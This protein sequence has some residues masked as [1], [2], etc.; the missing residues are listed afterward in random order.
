MQNPTTHDTVIEYRGRQIRIQGRAWWLE[1]AVVSVDG[2]LVEVARI[3]AVSM[4]DR[5]PSPEQLDAD[6]TLNRYWAD[7]SNHG[8]PV[9]F[10]LGFTDAELTQFGVIP[11]C[12]VFPS[13]I[14]ANRPATNKT[15][16]PASLRQ[17]Q[18]AMD[19]LHNDCIGKPGD[20]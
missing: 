5:Y 9:Q 14:P 7:P 17:Q 19:W 20:Y 4:N 10:M 3:H 2:K 8:K 1:S 12:L 6:P 18:Q 15:T 16:A 13:V 11:G